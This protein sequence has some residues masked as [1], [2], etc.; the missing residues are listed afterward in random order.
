MWLLLKIYSHIARTRVLDSALCTLLFAKLD[1]SFKI[2]LNALD[3][4]TSMQIILYSF[5]WPWQRVTPFHV[6][7]PKAMTIVRLWLSVGEVMTCAF[8]NTWSYHAKVTK[9]KLEWWSALLPPLRF[10][11]SYKNQ[12][13]TMNANIYCRDNHCLL[14]HLARHACGFINCPQMVWILYKMYRNA[15]Y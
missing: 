6:P 5:R 13:G 9:V 15:L 2:A 3:A 4:S 14:P 1:A 7:Y 11:V 8:P 12:G 10:F